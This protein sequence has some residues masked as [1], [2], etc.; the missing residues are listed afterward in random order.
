MA[1]SA[2]TPLL[3]GKLLATDTRWEII[4]Q[5]CDERTARER[6]GGLQKSRYGTLNYYL[7]DDPRH[8]KGYN[9]NKFTLNIKMKRYLTRLLKEAGL[10]MDEHYVNHLCYQLV[11]ENI[12]LLK[13][14]WEADPNSTEIF[15]FFQSCTWNDVRLKPPPSMDSDIGWRVEFRTIDAQTT[16]EQNF[17]FTHAILVLFR[18]LSCEQMR[19]NFYIPIS[20]VSFNF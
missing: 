6:D 13:K 1:L 8:L 4:E 15:E 2:S 20:K 17:L 3:K 11:R 5:S 18:L 12:C 10:T 16:P 7:S 14:D 19:L 9:D